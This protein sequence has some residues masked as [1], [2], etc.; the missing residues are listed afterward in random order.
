MPSRE[1]IP[2]SV[3]ILTH[4][5]A[6]N[7]GHCLSHLQSV[8]E[9]IIVDSGSTDDTIEIARQAR[10]NVRVSV[11][12]FTD[13]GQQR[14]WAIENTSAAF[15]WILFVDADEYCDPK[16]VEEV[17]AFLNAPGEVVGGYVAGRNYF[18]GTWLRRTMKYP[19]YQL[20]LLRVGHVRFRKDGHGQRE[21]V[22]GRCHWFRS[23]WRHEAFSKG[24]EQWIARHNR[25][26]TE[27]VARIIELRQ[28]PLHLSRLFSSN[29]AVRSR[30][31]WKLWSRVPGKPLLRFLE[32]YLLRLG[33]LD[34][35]A[36]FIYALLIMTHWVHINAKVQEHRDREREALCR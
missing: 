7:I 36:G 28:E 31:K 27:E 33:F 15:P 14:N 19:S 13:F 29:R 9:V 18:L 4:N 6:K 24:I 25:Y 8:Q 32:M 16:F 5:E 26:S 34:G 3:I 17:S 1:T 10:P 11:N 30:E 22:D 21:I 2:L 20:R 12:P 35:R 23:G